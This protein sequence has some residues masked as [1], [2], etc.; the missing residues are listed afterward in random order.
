MLMNRIQNYCTKLIFAL[1]D[2]FHF[3]L[4]PPK[5]I[6]KK[7]ITEKNILF[8]YWTGPES[9]L[10]KSLKWLAREHA[11]NGG[12]YKLV[13]LTPENLKEYIDIPDYFFDLIPAHQADYARVMAVGAYGGIW[14]DADVIIMDNL[15]SMFE[16][17]QKH[18]GFFVK[19]NNDTLYNG[20]FGSKPNTRMM[21]LWAYE[22]K[23]HIS[24]HNG[25]ARWEAIGAD[26][27][28]RLRKSPFTF[29]GFKKFNGLDSVYP[30]NWDQCL[31]AFVLSD[32][33]KYVEIERDFQPF[34][35]LVNSVYKHLAEA[36]ES[37][38][39]EQDTMPINYFLRKSKE[40]LRN[41][42]KN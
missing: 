5:L 1:I 39:F 14:L 7:K 35:V 2:T 36:T 4:G 12:N 15:A 19:Q 18:N 3:L 30:I 34:I 13:V 26:L 16:L 37:E 31:D 32:Y 42:E 28:Q 17:N 10:I 40:S 20:A 11:N 22:I 21:R 23:K 27:L 24:K 29:I 9:S 38:L 25:V 8:M 6:A 41:Y 33:N